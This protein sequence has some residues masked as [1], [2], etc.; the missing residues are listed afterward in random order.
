MFEQ[1]E[2]SPEFRAYALKR[3]SFRLAALLLMTVTAY[4]TGGSMVRPLLQVVVPAGMLALI[5]GP[6]VI[7][8]WLGK[9]R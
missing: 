1:P 4:V 8:Q 2:P 5:F 3:L 7:G 9:K 6:V